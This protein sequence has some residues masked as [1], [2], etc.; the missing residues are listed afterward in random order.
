MANYALK[1]NDQGAKALDIQQSVL[2]NAT[3]DAIREAG[4]QK[5]DHVWE[6]GCGNGAVTLDLARI[7]GAQGH[8]TAVDQSTEQLVRVRQKAVEEKLLNVNTKILDLDQDDLPAHDADFVFGRYVLVHLNSS[9]KLLA[10][11]RQNLLKK[12]GTALFIESAWSQYFE[13][14]PFQ[15]TLTKMREAYVSYGQSLGVD[16]NLGLT[17]DKMM[18]DCAFKEVTL[19]K[20]DVTY[21]ADLFATLLDIRLDEMGDQLVKAGFAS[22]NDLEA[23]RDIARDLPHQPQ[24]ELI[25]HIHCISGKA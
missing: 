19:T 7:A 13:D 16:Y 23:W 2:A 6:Y 21:S 11:T 18:I 20:K 9:E 24:K 15:E 4:L 1:T 22:P 12:G 10:K 8:V 17:L 14:W 25:Q 3:V 5:G